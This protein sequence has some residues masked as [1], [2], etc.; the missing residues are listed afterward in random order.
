MY[1]SHQFACLF[2]CWPW[3][4]TLQHNGSSV[5]YSH[6]SS[7][8]WVFLSLLV[9]QSVICSHFHPLLSLSPALSFHIFYLILTF[10]IFQRARRENSSSPFP[11]PSPHPSNSSPLS[12]VRISLEIWWVTGPADPSALFSLAV[13]HLSLHC[14]MLCTVDWV[15]GVRVKPGI[16]EI[17]WAW[18]DLEMREELCTRGEAWPFKSPSTG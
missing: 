2:R 11:A 6:L 4:G 15:C 13:Y 1:T 10:A 5:V 8:N 17:K 16:F 9:F 18:T 12:S 3:P 14:Y 7:S